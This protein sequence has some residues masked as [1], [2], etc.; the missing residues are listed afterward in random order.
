MELQSVERGGENLIRVPQC[1]CRWI[2]PR[3]RRSCV[4][5]GGRFDILE[6]LTALVDNSLLRQEET[7]E[8]EPR[9]WMLETIR[10]Y[11]LERLSESGEMEALRAQHARYFSDIILNQV[12]FQLYSAYFPG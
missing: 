8:S 6:G 3:S 9:F 1:V 10:A 5:R 4:Q 7:T 2:Y 11:A 12:G